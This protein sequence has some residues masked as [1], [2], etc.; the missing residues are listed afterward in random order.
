MGRS[1]RLPVAHVLTAGDAHL[2]VLGNFR[3]MVRCCMLPNV[4]FIT[5]L[6]IVEGGADT[7]IT[8]SFSTSLGILR[9]GKASQCDT[10]IV[11]TQGGAPGVI[12]LLAFEA[13]R[14]SALVEDGDRII[15]FTDD[16]HIRCELEPLG[17]RFVSPRVF[18]DHELW[19]A[20]RER[21]LLT[22]CEPPPAMAPG[23]SLIDAPTLPCVHAPPVSAGPAGDMEAFMA[24]CLGDA[25]SVAPATHATDVD[26]RAPPVVDMF[27]QAPPSVMVTNDASTATP[28]VVHTLV[29]KVDVISPSPT[30]SVPLH[31]GSSPTEHVDVPSK[32][33]EPSPTESVDV[34]PEHDGAPSADGCSVIPEHEGSPPAE[35]VGVMPECEGSPSTAGVDAI[36]EH[37]GATI[38]APES[39]GAACPSVGEDAG[40]P[41]PTA[42]DGQSSERTASPSGTEHS[43]K[44]EASEAEPEKVEESVVD[45]Q[46]ISGFE[47]DDGEERAYL[48]EKQNKE[49]QD[50]LRDLKRIV[51][52]ETRLNDIRNK[53]HQI[54]LEFREKMRALLK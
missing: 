50:R 2:R 14:L 42:E 16:T 36:Q 27:T 17:V 5:D 7:C 31:D 37:G 21:T 1:S 18:E 51:A 4:D 39:G 3:N 53:Q 40:S 43:V 19:W 13:G 32:C 12:P 22:T 44:L 49:T 29:D 8:L 20:M 34:T 45:S 23:A 9:E 24:L 33:E 54:E 25:A 26:T 6:F 38:T 52:E 41:S 11:K 15:M 10:R 30:K 35:N 47:D 48:L 46:P 28:T